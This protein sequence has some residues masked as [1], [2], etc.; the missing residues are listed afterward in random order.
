MDLSLKLASPVS[1]FFNIQIEKLLKIIFAMVSH[2]NYQSIVSSMSYAKRNIF[3]FSRQS[4]SLADLL[5][6]VY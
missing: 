3:T 5:L 1:I 6:L 2:L 4:N